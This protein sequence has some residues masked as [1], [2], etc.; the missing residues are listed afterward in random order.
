MMYKGYMYIPG[1]SIRALR[2]RLCQ[3][4]ILTPV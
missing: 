4:Y 2:S 3:R 1:L